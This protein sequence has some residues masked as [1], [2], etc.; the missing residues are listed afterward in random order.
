MLCFEQPLAEYAALLDLQD[1]CNV[2]TPLKITLDKS[3]VDFIY[4]YCGSNA[5]EWQAKLNEDLQ[6]DY[7]QHEQQV[8]QLAQ[9]VAVHVLLALREFNKRV[10]GRQASICRFSHEA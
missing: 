3:G 2:N 9:H 6:E 8:E 10:S 5:L 1:V 7:E 4:A